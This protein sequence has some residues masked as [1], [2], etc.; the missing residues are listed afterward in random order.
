MPEIG[1]TIS[2]Y[3]IVEKIGQGGMGEVYLADDTTLDRKVALKFLPEVFTS[4][5]ERMARFER[6]AKLLASLNHPNIAGIYGL[7]QA[8]GNR[9]LV[10]EYVEGETLQA[11]L[12]KGALSLEDALELCRQIAEGLEA[13]HE[14]GVIHRDLKPANVMITA[15]EK[16]KILD[17]GLAKAFSDETQSIDSSQ[18]PTLTEA[19]TQ[20]GVILG[21]AAYMS[22]EQAKGKSVDKRADIWA[23]GCI[24]YECLTGKRAFEGETIT[25]TLAA[26]LRGEPDWNRLTPNLH[27]RISLLFERCLEKHSKDRYGVI[28]DARVD[29]QKVLTDP[30]GVLVKPVTADAT[31]RKIRTML[32]WIAAAVI[33]AGVAVWIL[34][35]SP[36]PE[37]KRVTR[38]IHEL[39]DGQQFTRDA[40]GEAQ[41]NLAISPDGSQF[42]YA[43]TNGLYL[44]SMK[45]YDAKLIAG[46]DGY[47]VQPF[48]SPD[49]QSIGYLSVSDLKLKKIAISGGPPVVLCDTGPLVFGASWDLEDT[50][51]YSDLQSGIMRVSA[52]WGTP[53]P[54]IKVEILKARES[55]VPIFPQMLPD[56]K[57]IL[58]T[59]L[60]GSGGLN[61]QIEAQS[62]ETGDRRLLVKGGLLAKYLTSGHIVYRSFTNN[63]RNLYAVPFDSKKLEVGGQVSLLQG[64]QDLAISDSGTLVYVP[65][66]AV[67]SINGTGIMQLGRLVWVDKKGNEEPLAAKPDRYGHFSISPDGTRVA[68]G[69]AATGRSDI[70]I[71]DFHRENRTR[72][73]FDEGDEA[74]PIWTPDSKRIIYTVGG[75]SGNSICSKAADGT[76]ETEKLFTGTV[77]PI[78]P[79][80]SSI[81]GKTLV[82]WTITQNPIN[83]NVEI[84]SMEGEHER[85]PLL[86]TNYNEGYPK[87]SPKGQWIAYQSDAS[88]KNK[89]YVSSFPDVNQG[90][91]T[92][93]TNGG[94]S[95]L[96]SPDGSE[97]F[98]R[99]GDSFMAV[100]VETQPA[101][102]SGKPKLLFRGTY[103]TLYPS[104]PSSLMDQ[105]LWDIHP[106]GKRFLMVKPQATTGETS[107]EAS[108]PEVSRKINIVLNWFE[109]LKEKVPVP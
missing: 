49:G 41:F 32:P 92:I 85:T 17:F 95:P 9:F 7:E 28:S 79:F 36:P 37:P 78:Y 54:L 3:R 75:D 14:K 104:T 26:I 56:G 12:I 69:V 22:P 80:S 18:S 24:L 96:W 34:K 76:G 33:V 20:P 2:H 1:Q 23:F 8:D 16:V 64:V 106:D 62:L 27:P 71:W 25:E 90:K 10:L 66:T 68:L 35:P 43:T 53:E 21:T 65:Q 82:L 40:T 81:D 39:S 44:R 51:V 103:S 91:W 4:D 50:I 59:T 73:T 109:E 99:S 88:G 97:L 70:W 15:E 74:T 48:F 52:K 102:S 6:E 61:V 108:T 107:T 47:S 55:G 72:I 84:L 31:Q 63:V 89:V 94:D 5:P 67:T 38:F 86:Q 98:Y 19:M 60:S 11:K 29:I 57:T 93:S 45:E 77:E 46:T 13:A 100:D 30:S 42:V 101:F 105:I 58:F 83:S 87:I